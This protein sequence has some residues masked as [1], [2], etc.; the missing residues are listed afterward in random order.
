MKEILEFLSELKENNHRDWFLANKSRYEKG[1]ELL[2]GL[3][4]DLIPALTKTDPGLEGLQPKDCL[5]RINRDIR[6]SHDKSPYKTN[7]G[8]VLAPGGR[9]TNKGCYYIHLEPDSC[10][11]AGG[12]YMP[13]PEDLKRI[14]EEID[15]NLSE[16]EE[17][18][19][20]KT[21]TKH[22]ASGLDQELRLKTIPKG[23]DAENPAIEY[24]KLKSFTVSRYLKNEE[25]A[26]LN[27]K[28]ILPAFEALYPLNRFLNR[29]LETD[30]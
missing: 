24:L 14:R 15:Y 22:Y 21:F 2:T 25:A 9:K 19:K 17:I 13:M 12:V 10:F 18:L 7:M 16:F 30:F 4:D 8:A 28:N 20:D 1:K 11:L 6:F 23:Y 27:L 26:D 3:L 5:F 29:S